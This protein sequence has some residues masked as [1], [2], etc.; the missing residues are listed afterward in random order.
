MEDLSK[1]L[2]KE[3]ER[4]TQERDK[5]QKKIN[6]INEFYQKMAVEKPAT[7][8][9]QPPR[10][11]RVRH[12]KT[13]DP[14]FPPAYRN[15]RTRDRIVKILKEG[16]KK[17][18]FHVREVAEALASETRLQAGISVPRPERLRLE[19]WVGNALLK[20]K[21]VARKRSVHRDGFYV[22]LAYRPEK[23]D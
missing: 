1:Q 13:L 21:D 7:A 15:L 3:V 16:V 4:L 18:V 14:N 5:I 6:Y 22:N 11:P 23:T 12:K 19:K 17:S 10:R 8:Q 9:K 2:V 20:N